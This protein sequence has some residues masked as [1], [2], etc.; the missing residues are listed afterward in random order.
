MYYKFTYEL[1]N[2]PVM[3]INNNNNNNNNYIAQKN[4]HK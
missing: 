3:N 2:W 4:L 1:Q